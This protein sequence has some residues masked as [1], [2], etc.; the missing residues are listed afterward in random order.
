MLRYL[1][2]AAAFVVLV[3]FLGIGL[4]LDPS[5]VPSPLID[6]PAPAFTLPQLKDP[7]LSFSHRDLQGEVSL[8]NVW[9]TWCG[10]CYQEHP[11]LVDL[12]GSKQVPIY[13]L[14]LKDQRAA[15]IKWLETYGN[16]Y[17]A[18]AFDKQ[19]R[20]AID[21]GVYGAPETF[22]VDA[23]GVI[24]YKHIGPLTAEVLQKTILPLVSRLRK[25]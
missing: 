4:K 15:A 12:A 1:L 8:V 5:L 22:V 24:R 20:V 2:P 18:I 16:P 21:W 10:A 17:T 14:N 25:S 13:G 6:K 11:V 3:V 23:K 7:G 19:G 9:A